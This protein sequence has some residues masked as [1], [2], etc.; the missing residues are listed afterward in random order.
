MNNQTGEL[1][2]F[3]DK[4]ELKRKTEELDAL[5]QSMSLLQQSPSDK[6]PCCKGAGSVKI[7]IPFYDKKGRIHRYIPCF[8]TYLRS[9]L[10]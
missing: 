2:L 1:Y 8:C 6:C 9:L 3:K 7:E 10:K 5:K 4:E